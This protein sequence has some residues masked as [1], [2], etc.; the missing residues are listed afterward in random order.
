MRGAQQAQAAELAET[1][2]HGGARGWHLDVRNLVF[3]NEQVE[4]PL[5]DPTI[6][7]DDLAGLMVDLHPGRRVAGQW[8]R[9]PAEPDGLGGKGFVLFGHGGPS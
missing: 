4:S 6:E 1:Q 8:R 9:W 3:G 5:H 2:G 7:A